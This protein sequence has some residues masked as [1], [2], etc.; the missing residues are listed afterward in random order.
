MPLW[1][2][3]HPPAVFT[4]QASK[5][6]LAKNIMSIYTDF[7]M[8][9]FYVNVIFH[10]TPGHNVFIGGVPQSLPSGE[11]SAETLPRPFIRLV[12]EHIAYNHGSNTEGMKQFCDQFDKGQK[13]LFA[14]VVKVIKP[15]IGDKGYDWEY[16][17]DE[18]PTDFWRVQGLKPPPYGSEGM[19]VWVEANKAVPWEKL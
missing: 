9:A 3:Y 5:A 7:G 13:D 18:T 8:P 16:H 14:V 4:D 6:G 15:Y 11:S 2:I 17:V 1:H 19:K 12:G 10:P